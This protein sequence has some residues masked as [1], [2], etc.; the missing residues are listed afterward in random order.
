MWWY[1]VCVEM[2][3]CHTIQ[4][5]NEI[6]LKMFFCWAKINVKK[7]LIRGDGRIVCPQGGWRMCVCGG[8]DTCAALTSGEIKRNK[9]F[10]GRFYHYMNTSLPFDMPACS[11]AA[12]S[13]QAELAKETPQC[14]FRR[15]QVVTHSDNVHFLANIVLR[16]P[17]WS[18]VGAG[19]VGDSQ[20]E[21]LRR[22]VALQAAARLPPTDF[23]G[24]CLPLLEA[25]P[26]ATLLQTGH[27]HLGQVLLEPLEV[28]PE[29]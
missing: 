1:K 19:V 7:Q 12:R 25:L 5:G 2:C 26:P 11:A 17:L 18:Q 9:P 8:G 28:L 29:R 3:R 27:D 23:G 22:A 10:G 13:G 15:V 6:Q 4:K 21:V 16:V 14:W 24:Q 20:V